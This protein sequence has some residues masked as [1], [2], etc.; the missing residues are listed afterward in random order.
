MKKLLPFLTLLIFSLFATNALAQEERCTQNLEEAQLRYD[1]GRIQDVEPLVLNCLETNVFDKAQSVQALRLLILS[2]IFQHRDEQA[3]DMMLELLKTDHEFVPD[4]AL[5]PVEFINLYNS[6]RTKPIF[7]IGFKGGPNITSIQAITLYTTGQSGDPG[8]F[9]YIAKQGV[10][11]GLVFEYEFSPRWTIYPELLYSTRTFDNVEEFGGLTDP[12]EVVDRKEETERQTWLELPVSVQYRLKD[13]N[14][15]PYVNAGG[16]ASYLIMAEYPAS[17]NSLNRQKNPIEN[18]LGEVTDERNQ[19]NFYAFLGGGVKIKLGE[20]YFV[21]ELR[22]NYGIT[23]VSTGE[24]SF[25]PANKGQV[26]ERVI[27]DAYKEHFATFTV[28]YTLN[29][30]KPRKL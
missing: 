8:A 17:D 2:A 20:G 12:T 3:D 9:E 25:S 26:P 29:I 15:R 16:S 28:G 4:E 13:G 27:P 30:Y 24:F 22:A 18:T 6:Y 23:E 14:I 19:L 21:A 5:D 1:E 7:R 10:T 11:G